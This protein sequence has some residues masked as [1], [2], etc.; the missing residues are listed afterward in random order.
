MTSAIIVK[1]LAASRRLLVASPDYLKRWGKPASL[2][3]L[4]KHRGVIY[5]N[6][7]S[8]DWRFRVGRKFQTVQPSAVLRVNNGMLMRDAAIAGL[9]I[10]L[11]PT[12]LLEAPLLANRRT[13]HSIDIG[14]QAEGATI[15]I[16]YPEHLRASMK[17]RA[18][19][20]CLQKSFV[21][22]PIGTEFLRERRLVEQMDQAAGPL[23]GRE[24]R[25][26]H[27]SRSASIA[28]QPLSHLQEREVITQAGPELHE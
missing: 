28:T 16:A 25:D 5:S 20:A 8:A 24:E 22:P 4:A 14:A 11:L 7:G 19:T 9:G 18:L 23:I 10:A 1:Y 2:E 3:D 17:I 12:F 13:L 26:D 27:L 6:R 21:I 15:Y